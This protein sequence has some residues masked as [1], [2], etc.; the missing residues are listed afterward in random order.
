M[1]DELSGTAWMDADQRPPVAQVDGFAIVDRVLSHRLI[2]ELTLNAWPSLQTLLFDGWLLSFS[3]GYTRRANSIHPLYAACQP[4]ADKI[5]ECEAAYAGRGQPTVF[6]ITS[7]AEDAE[8][9]AV[10]PR[11]GY[12]SGAETSVQTRGTSSLRPPVLDPV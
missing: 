12:I 2:E 6:K 3:N 1:T 9:D 11:A 5:A 10:L 4:L 7:A 8:L